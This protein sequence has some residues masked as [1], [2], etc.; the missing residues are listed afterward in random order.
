MIHRIFSLILAIT[1]TYLAIESIKPLPAFHLLSLFLPSGII[2]L[3]FLIPVLSFI[4]EKKVFGNRYFALLLFISILQMLSESELFEGIVDTLYVLGFDETSRF[5]LN[6]FTFNGSILIP[7]LISSMFL[8]SSYAERIAE[9]VDRD[10]SFSRLPT[11]VML[12]AFLILFYAIGKA[13][14]Q[15]FSNDFLIGLI[16]VFLIVGG[17]ASLWWYR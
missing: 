10:Y 7:F 5:L 8:I 17:V 14:L 1:A 13:F 4:Y 15:S 11:L 3:L 9:D 12:T 6:L 2:Y 16:A